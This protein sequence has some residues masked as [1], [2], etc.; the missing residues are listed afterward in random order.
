VLAS[1][2]NRLF[3]TRAQE[4]LLKAA[5]FQGAEALTAWHEWKIL[6]DL[7]ANNDN[8]TFRLLPLLYTNL[9]RHAV[10]DP[11]INI[12]KGIYRKA[13]YKNH[14][15]FHD[16]AKTASHFQK[17]GVKTMLLKGAP[18]TLLHYKNYAVRPMADID[19]LTPSSQAPLAMNVLSNE[20][21]IPMHRLKNGD[22]R[23]YHA[24]PFKNSSGTELDLHWYPYRGC[25][26][27]YCKDFWNRAV[28]LEFGDASTLAPDATDMLF[29]IIIHGL[30]WNREPPIRWIADSMSLIK[31]SNAQIDWMRLIDCAIKQR[32]S[33]TVREALTYLHGTFHANIPPSIIEATHR[34]PISPL[35]IFI[36]R[37]ELANPEL[38][39]DIPIAGFISN[40]YEGL[41]LHDESPFFS[42]VSGL[43]NFL[44]YR[45]KAT[46]RYHLFRL[47]IFKALNRL[48]R[49]LF[50]MRLNHHYK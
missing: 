37:Y 11:A 42:R 40:V 6:V 31:S 27:S 32:F 19:I 49:M 5:L 36:C 12:L 39:Y 46:S 34:I 3:A 9:Q 45:F 21:W 7:E 25:P 17:S 14:T 15:L 8:G 23:Y 43:L 30:K 24:M 47:I 35:D 1:F 20:G 29:H 4:L 22:L 16:I 41:R 2:E 44:Q 50:R 38:K 28:P 13:W 18:L 33:P 10:K 26:E 48:K